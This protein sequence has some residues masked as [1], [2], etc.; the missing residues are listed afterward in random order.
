MCTTVWGVV[1]AIIMVGRCL[2]ILQTRF[3]ATRQLIRPSSFP[4]LFQFFGSLIRDFR[5]TTPL[6]IFSAGT[7]FVW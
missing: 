7:M 2:L 3:S 1:L 5:H 4:R 6:G